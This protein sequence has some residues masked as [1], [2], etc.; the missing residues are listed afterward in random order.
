MNKSDVELLLKIGAEGGELLIHRY[1][2]E[3]GQMEI[4]IYYRRVCTC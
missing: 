1:Q 4:C 2:N 3:H